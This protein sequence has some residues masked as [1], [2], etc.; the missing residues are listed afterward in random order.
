ML[1]DKSP[2]HE[3]TWL[4]LEHRIADATKLQDLLATSGGMGQNIQDAGKSI[5]DTARNILGLN[6]NRR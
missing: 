6:F 1:Q 3:Q 4:F 5:F 2:D